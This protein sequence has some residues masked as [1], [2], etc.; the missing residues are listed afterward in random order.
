[1]VFLSLTF[2]LRAVPQKRPV[3]SLVFVVD[4][5]QSMNTMDYVTEA[6]NK[7]VLPPLPPGEGGGEG[8]NSISDPLTLTLSRKE[9]GFKP[10]SRLERVKEVLRQVIQSLPCQSRVGLGLF[11]ERRSVLLFTPIEVCAHYNVL[12]ETLTQ[13]D[14]RM[15]WAADSNIAKGL[16]DAMEL[17]RGLDSAL[18]FVTDGQEAP[19]LNPRYRESFESAANKVSGLIVGTG[20]LTPTPIPKY[21]EMGEAMGFY[22][23][24]EVPHASRF[25]LPGQNPTDIEGYEPRNAPFGREAT[26]GQEHLSAV[27]E[28]YLKQLSQETGLAYHRLADFP[29]FL[30]ALT[31]GSL[32]T[33]QTVPTDMRW[34]PASLALSFLTA[35]YLVAPW[36]KPRPTNQSHQLSTSK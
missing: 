19:P 22:T 35:M 3:Y 16:L 11:T 13:I 17:V 24:E 18:V 29:G 28:P 20:G 36:A 12:D 32:A 6:P 15:A 4:I 25:G 34:L 1:L 30:E 33:H 27:R 23:A 10:Q 5:T 21:G 9:R 2:F 14:W 26:V 8:V 31:A 7:S